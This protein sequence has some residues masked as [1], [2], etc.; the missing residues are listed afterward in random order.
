MDYDVCWFQKIEIDN[1][2]NANHRQ[3][4]DSCLTSLAVIV[5]SSHTIDSQQNFPH[6]CHE[7]LK[8]ICKETLATHHV[9]ENY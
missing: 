3:N 2:N 1:S 8:T 4:S 5:Q 6:S 9:A 7:F